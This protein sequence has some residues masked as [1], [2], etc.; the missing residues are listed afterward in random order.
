MIHFLTQWTKYFRNIP[1]LSKIKFQV[2][3]GII[4]PGYLPEA[5]EILKKKKGGN[6]CILQVRKLHRQFFPIQ[7]AIIK[8]MMV[9]HVSFYSI[10]K[11]LIRLIL[12][13]NLPSWKQGLCLDYSSIRNVM[14][15]SSTAIWWRMLLQLEKR[16]VIIVPLTLPL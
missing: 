10:F 7:Y 2:S 8:S 14:M 1:R 13:M 11:F 9:V 16:Y 4:A 15:Q 6:Y 3:D 12:H 5:L